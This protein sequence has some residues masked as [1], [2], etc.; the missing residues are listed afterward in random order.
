MLSEKGLLGMTIT[1]EDVSFS[2]G[3][4]TVLSEVTG[5]MGPGIVGLIGVNGAGKTTLLRLLATVNRADNGRLVIEGSD[6]S[7]RTGRRDVRSGL[8]Y[9]PQS[10][11]WNPR[12]TILELC[13][14][15]AWLHGVPRRHRAARAEEAIASVDLTEHAHTRLGDLSGGQHRRAM[16]AQSIV[17]EPR[18]LIL[19]EPTTGL[20]PEQRVSFRKLLR[21]VAADRTVVLST[22]LIE[23]VAHT[24]DQVAV[25]HN[26]RFAFNGTTDDLRAHAYTDGPG[27]SPLEQAFH[28]IIS[29]E[30]AQA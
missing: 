5:S 26:G 6:P 11:T 14:Y 16:I 28:R 4:H 27:D 23:D 18:L 7:N 3:S 8:G 29:E 17:H 22:H 15:F 9:L 10:A 24:A 30:A 21:N 25:L 19:D 13:H 20:D 1:L 2:Y 12:F